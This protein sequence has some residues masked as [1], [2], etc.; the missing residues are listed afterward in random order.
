MAVSII[1]RRK[2]FHRPGGGSDRSRI[3]HRRRYAH[4]TLPNERFIQRVLLMSPSAQRRSRSMRR[5]RSRCCTPA[6]QR[7]TCFLGLRGLLVRF[8]GHDAPSSQQFSWSAQRG[9]LPPGPNRPPLPPERAQGEGDHS[10]GCGRAPR[11]RNQDSGRYS[12][13]GANNS[14]R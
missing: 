10:A 9:N 7:H 1:S 12:P 5:T 13:K 14:L 6:V 3:E 4:L 11:R 8:P 2:I